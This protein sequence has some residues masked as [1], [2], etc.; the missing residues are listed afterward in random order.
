[1]QKQPTTTRRMDRC[2]GL[3]AAALIVWTVVVIVGWYRVSSYSFAADPLAMTGAPKHWPAD[4]IIAKTDK[5]PTLLLFLHPKCPCSR[6]TV[7]ELERLNTLVP[8]QRLPNICIVATAPRSVGDLWWSTALLSRAGRLPNAHIILDPGG[9]EA[10]L[11]E[12]RTSGTVLLFNAQGE[13]LYAGG[14]T[15]ARGHDGHNAGLQ[16]VADLLIDPSA[17]RPA[18]PPFGCSV[19]REDVNKA[20]EEQLNPDLQPNDTDDVDD[21]PSSRT[22]S[23]G[24]VPA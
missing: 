24:D 11:F 14:V 20:T 2:S 21:A 1:M 13:Q 6:A 15:L 12:A 22:S 7:A 9:V 8:L 10:A 17:H 16:A 18:I 4:S 5:R 19:Y 23:A 3:L